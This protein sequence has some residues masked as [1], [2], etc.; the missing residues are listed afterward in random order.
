LYRDAQIHDRQ[1]NKV[2]ISTAYISSPTVT[3]NCRY[4]VLFS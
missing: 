4:S 3:I 2:Y 1:I